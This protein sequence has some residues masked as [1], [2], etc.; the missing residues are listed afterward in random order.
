MYKVIKLFHDMED[1]NYE[2]NPANPA[3]NT[4][5]RNG[6]T[7]T[8]ERIAELSGKNNRQGT[9]LIAKVDNAPAKPKKATKKANS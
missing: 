9:P 5:P 4:Y 8:A 1:N 2:Y 3:C 7:P 6:L